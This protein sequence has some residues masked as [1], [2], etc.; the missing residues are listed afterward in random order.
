[1]RTRTIAGFLLLLAAPPSCEPV[2]QPH[3]AGRPI[4]AASR[5]AMGPPDT[6]PPMDVKKDG[7]PPV[8]MPPPPPP[9]TPPASPDAGV[10]ADATAADRPSSPTPAIC[11]PGAQQCLPAEVARIRVCDSQ[12]RWDFGRCPES[13]AC[14]DDACVPVCNGLLTESIP[15]VCLFPLTTGSD[16][17][18][19]RMTNDPVRFPLTTAV[20]VWVG[21]RSK[22]TSVS[23]EPG[24][25][26]PLAWTISY[27]DV[28]ASVAFSLG[29]FNRPVNRVDFIYRARRA[30]VVQAITTAGVL[31]TANG[32]EVGT[33]YQSL[34]ATWQVNEANVD[35]ALTPQ[36]DHSPQANNA[37]GVG[38]TGDGFGTF[39]DFVRLNWILLRVR[40]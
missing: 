38:V 29:A 28:G 20:K 36:L 9:P 39:P 35:R 23:S 18:I 12:G 4:D 21:S 8:T 40:Q 6:R 24:G 14:I 17:L 16:P 33:A 30:G 19:G 32:N 22:A 11:A 10:G 37:I 7:P 3:D 2:M 31:V 25:G 26:W 1:M 5:P 15:S 27:P 34:S 13:Q